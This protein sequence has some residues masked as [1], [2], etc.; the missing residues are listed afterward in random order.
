MAKHFPAPGHSAT[1]ALPK[2]RQDCK[3]S[4]PVGFFKR[5][6][7]WADAEPTASDKH[8]TLKMRIN[9]RTSTHKDGRSGRF[10]LTFCFVNSAWPIRTLPAQILTDKP[11][12]TRAGRESARSGTRGSNQSLQSSA[13]PAPVSATTSAAL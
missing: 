13:E 5:L 7:D 1:E 2:T 6:F 4:A 12:R 9:I 10:K 11:L 8:N 3:P